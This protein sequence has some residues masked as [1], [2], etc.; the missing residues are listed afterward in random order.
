[1]TVMAGGAV[2]LPYCCSEL[3]AQ[4]EP[5]VVPSMAWPPVPL[6][7]A[8]SLFSM[9]FTMFGAGELDLSPL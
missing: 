6:H 1:M 7:Y 2:A 4:A 9:M 5:A 3:F 8:S